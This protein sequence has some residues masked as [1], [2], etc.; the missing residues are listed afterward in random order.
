MK[1][2]KIK[3]GSLGKAAP[4][5]DVQV[6]WS[7]FLFVDFIGSKIQESTSFGIIQWYFGTIQGR[8]TFLVELLAA[9]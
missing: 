3:P 4:P 6:W 9:G 2:M 1:G 7:P 5:Y 8:L